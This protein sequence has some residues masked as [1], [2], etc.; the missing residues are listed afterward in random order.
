[1]RIVARLEA[2]TAVAQVEPRRGVPQLND[3]ALAAPAEMVARRADEVRQRAHVVVRM[4]DEAS[5]RPIDGVKVSLSGSNREWTTSRNGEFTLDVPPGTYSIA[6]TH[7]TYGAGSGRL[8]VNARGTVQY[9]LRLPRRTVTLEPLA[10]VAQ[11][12]YPGFFDPRARGR[13][14]N[15][16]MRDEIERRAS[17]VLNIGDL[18]RTSI[19][20][21][22]V[23]DIPAGNSGGFIKEV[24]ITDRM[25]MPGQNDDNSSDRA[26]SSS[27][28]SR[29]EPG[30]GRSTRMFDVTKSSCT[31]G[32]AVALDDMVIG[33]NAAEFLRDFPI[34]GIESIIYV[35]PTDAASRYGYLA[36]NGIILI[37]TRGNGPTVRETP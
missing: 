8:T 34:A 37:Y 33:G 13:H 26:T 36:R 7:P 3:L 17:S 4:V 22:V 35:K 6:F 9:A 25:A 5:G 16:V 14:L 32:V 18:V 30:Q 29:G 28:P 1:V 21:L 20:S 2:D 31:R 15:I 27:D 12:V 24:C 11:R 19:P 23:T 10:V